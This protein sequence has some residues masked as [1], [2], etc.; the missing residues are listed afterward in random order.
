MVKN[1]RVVLKIT[2]PSFWTKTMSPAIWHDKWKM[3][4]NEVL[5]TVINMYSFGNWA[6]IQKFVNVV[7]VG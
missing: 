5:K 2:I 6:K 7:N 1:Q 3:E 4:E